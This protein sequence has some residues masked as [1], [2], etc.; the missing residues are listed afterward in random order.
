MIGTG[1]TSPHCPKR[2]PQLLAPLQN[3]R[4]EEVPGGSQL[5]CCFNQESSRPPR[6]LQHTPLMCHW[7]ELGL[8]KDHHGLKFS[9]YKCWL[10][11]K[12]F[13]PNCPQQPCK[14]GRPGITYSHFTGEETEAQ[15]HQEP[16]TEPAPEHGFPAPSSAHSTADKILE[17]DNLPRH[18][19]VSGTQPCRE[20][21]TILPSS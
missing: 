12:I 6:S 7:S 16:I 11:L 10:L 14:V 20:A 18:V 13:P 21:G 17:P 1:P 15:S 2:I 4:Q 3:S 19:I 8:P 5:L 9:I